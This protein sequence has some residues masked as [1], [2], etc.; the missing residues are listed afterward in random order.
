MKRANVPNDLAETILGLA[1]GDYERVASQYVDGFSPSQSSVSS[2]FQEWA[3]K[4]LEEF[5]NRSLEEENFLALWIDGKHVAGEQ[6]L[7]CVG[8]TEAGYKKVFFS[9]QATTENR[10][11]IK[12]ML[13][14]LLD[15]GLEFENGILCVVDGLKG[16]RQTIREV[17]GSRAEDQRCQWHKREKWSVTS[18]RETKASVARSS[19]VLTGSRPMK[20]QGNV[21]WN[22]KI[23]SSRSIGRRFG[24]VQEGLE[25]TLTL[26]R[27][28]LLEELGRILNTTNG[29]ENLMAKFKGASAG[30]G[31][32]TTLRRDTSGWSWCCWRSNS[33][34]VDSAATKIFQN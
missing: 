4:A 6:T 2:R 25:E 14:D 3:Q 31:G 32:D 1:Q 8:V 9:T 5:E 10:R 21:S 17:F 27:L 30:S 28:G 29:I 20:L 34:C 13:C 22:C 24:P 19:N 15:R 26:H 7:V 11:P 16:L 33:E 12:D 18:R 23:I